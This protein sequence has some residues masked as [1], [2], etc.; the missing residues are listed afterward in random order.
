MQALK[1]ATGQRFGRLIV[2]NQAEKDKKGQLRWNCLCDC[3]KFC[4]VAS[5]RLHQGS[6]SSC[7]VYDENCVLKKAKTEPNTDMLQVMHTQ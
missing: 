5:T 1:I 6:V 4:I 7:G 3:G 2:K